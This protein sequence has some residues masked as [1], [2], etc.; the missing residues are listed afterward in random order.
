MS[1]PFNQF[2]FSILDSD[3]DLSDFECDNQDL[4]EFLQTDAI[5]Y[6]NERLAVTRLIYFKDTPAGYFTLVSDSIEVAAIHSGDGTTEYPYRRYPALKI[7]RLATDRRYQKRG[8]GK[9]MLL[10]TMQIAIVLSR[11]VG[12]R[13][14]TVDSKPDSV[15]FYEKFGFRRATRKYHD[16]ISLYRDF[17]RA[18]CDIED[19]R[20]EGDIT[21]Y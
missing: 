2:S 6:Q 18:V 16:T 9:A 17:H 12:V 1:I 15:K 8:V 20:L 4:N 7:A 10:K 19:E 11:Y 3:T 13:I 5:Q 14:I 21:E